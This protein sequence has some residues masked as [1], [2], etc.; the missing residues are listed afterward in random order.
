MATAKKASSRTPLLERLLG[1]VG[2][3]LLVACVVF[4]IYEGTHGDEKPGRVTASIT[5]I[6]AADDMYIVTFDL[7]NAGTQTLSNVQ[8]TARV[9]DNERERR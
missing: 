7:H 2:V 4:L 1:G 9:T 6:V 5:E 3:V 8:V